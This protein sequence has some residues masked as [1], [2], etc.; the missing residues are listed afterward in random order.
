MCIHQPGCFVGQRVMSKSASLILAASL[1]PCERAML[2]AWHTLCGFSL[3]ATKKLSHMTHF[4]VRLNV[5]FV[6][7]SSHAVYRSEGRLSAIDRPTEHRTIFGRVRNSGWP[8][9]ALAQLK[10]SREQIC[11]CARRQVELET[12]LG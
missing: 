7:C 2:K 12:L 3:L 5:S 1:Q 9:Q 4:T 6:G 11:S 10:Q 8:T